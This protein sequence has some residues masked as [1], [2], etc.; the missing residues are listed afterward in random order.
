VRWAYY[1][2]FD[3]QKAAWLRELMARNVIAPGVVDERSVADVR[4]DELS[5]YCQ[6]HFFAGI[7]IWSYSLRLAGWSDDRPVWT[8]SCPCQPFSAA[9]KRKGKTDERHLFPAW[10]RL[11]E[12]R[13]PVVVFGEQVSSAD[14]LS[15]FNDVQ[16]SLDSAGYTVGALDTCAAGVGAPHIRQRLYFV[17]QS[18][19]GDGWPM[20]CEV[21]RESRRVQREPV[22]DGGAT[23]IVAHCESG[24]RGELRY[25]AHPG[26]GRHAD[27]GVQAGIVAHDDGEGRG[28]GG[29][30][31]HGNGRHASGY[32]ADGRGAA[33]E[34]AHA[35]AL[36]RNGRR[37]GEEGTAS[38]AFERPERLRAAG[39]L[40]DT[41]GLRRNG[42]RLGDGEPAEDGGREDVFASQERG[43]AGILGDTA[44]A[45]PLP[46]AHGRVRGSEEGG[47]PRD[48]EPERPGIAGGMDESATDGRQHGAAVDGIDGEGNQPREPGQQPGNR[49]MAGPTN[50]FWRDAEWVYC[51]DNKWRPVERTPL[52]LA[53]G[54]AVDLGSVRLGGEEIIHPLQKGG[55][56]RILRLRG[57]GDA[58]VSPVAAMFIRACM[59]EL[60]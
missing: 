10:F 12:A 49:C 52:G 58:I 20:L 56:A 8:G 23:G 47:R 15:W 51:R 39:I 45:G 5:G 3:P 2:E 37:T 6:C 16:H 31:H 40:G 33:G 36:G 13:R 41:A 57:Y 42:G 28:V 24:G 54:I 14:G 30:A 18:D 4:P 17:A 32:D 19:R 22:S 38:G 21:A 50:G 48:A 26:S 60:A 9:G 34:L 7:G 53:D 43:D 46:G 1:N 59:E 11:I 27:C 55:K 25:E 44:A 29:P 35:A